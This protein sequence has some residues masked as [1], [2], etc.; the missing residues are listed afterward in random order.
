M[1]IALDD[2]QVRVQELTDD[3]YCVH[4]GDSSRAELLQAVGLLRAR[5]LVVAVDKTAALRIVQQA[6]RQIPILV[7]SWPL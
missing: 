2:D 4:Y 1:V 3:E 6:R 5:L 7:H